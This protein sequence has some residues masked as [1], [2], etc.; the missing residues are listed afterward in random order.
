MEASIFNKIIMPLGIVIIMYGLGL[1]LTVVD[2]RRVW[3]N[4]KVMSTGI[5]LQIV[6]LPILGFMFCYAL[7]LNPVMAMSVMLLSSSPGG[8]ITNLVSFVSKGDAALSVSLT[9]VN[10]FITVVT[11]PIVVTLSLGHFLGAEAAAQV[12]VW[13]LSLGI[14]AI[15][16]PPI[17]L[18]MLTKQKLPDFAKKS[19]KWVRRGTIAFLATIATIV[20][21]NERALITEHYDEMTLLAVALCL[22]SGI[23]GMTVA[24]AVRFPRKHVLTL[25]I[26]VGLHNSAMAIAIAMSFLDMPELSI[27]SAFYLLVEYI[28]S[29]ILMGIMSSSVGDRILGIKGEAAGEVAEKATEKIL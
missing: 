27:F 10:S 22:L 13:K 14:L 28:I 7:H 17:I 23:M 19:E 29:G 2:F 20:C 9:A 8:A 6:G 1:S 16:I 11:I 3:T 25:S 21:I 4:P 12:R 24:S 5:A 26:E 15:T 18:G